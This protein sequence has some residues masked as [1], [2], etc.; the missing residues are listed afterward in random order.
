V[1]DRERRGAVAYATKAWFE[2]S[3]QT[4]GGPA[5]QIALMQHKLVDEKRRIGQ[6]RF[7]HCGH[8]HRDPGSPPDRQAFESLPSAR[9]ILLVVLTG[10]ALWAAPIVAVS[11]LVESTTVFR[12]QALSVSL[13]V[14]V[15]A[16]WNPIALALTGVALALTT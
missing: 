12:D 8:R 7:L 4:F 10:L 11:L 6:Q 16:S 5:G 2:I 13:D 3:V 9:R 15:L 14:P 1:F